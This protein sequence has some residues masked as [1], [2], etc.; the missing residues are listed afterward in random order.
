[1][2]VRLP[3]DRTLL[4]F[5]AGVLYASVAGEFDLETLERYVRPTIDP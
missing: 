4:G 2:S 1:M 3:P 5:G